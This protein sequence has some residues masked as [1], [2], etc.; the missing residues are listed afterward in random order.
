MR[1]YGLA[2]ILLMLAGLSAPAQGTPK[3]AAPPATQPAPAAQ[4]AA[5][6]LHLQRWEQ[7]MTDLRSL[8]CAI[9]RIDKDKVA[10]VVTNLVGTALYMKDGKGAATEHRAVLE[11]RYERNKELA[12]KVIITGTHIYQFSP[13]AKEIKVFDLPKPKPGQVGDDNVLSFLFGMKAESAKKRYD[14]SLTPDKVN[15]PYYVYID[16]KPLQQADKDEFLRARIVLNRDS[17]LPRQVWFEDRNG[18]QTTWDIDPKYLRPNVEIKRTEFDPPR[19]PDNT[20]KMVHGQKESAPASPPK[21]VQAK[22]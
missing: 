21:P 16:V 8:S 17:Y 1:P 6:D 9:K 22:P 3:T 4:P 13:A 19:L 18:K 14:M 15:D 11:L 2:L 10:D 5:L 7:K 20:W 12:E